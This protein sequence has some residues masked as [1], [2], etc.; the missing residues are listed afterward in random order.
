MAELF[1]LDE[2]GTGEGQEGKAAP[3]ETRSWFE[4]VPEAYREVPYLQQFKDKNFD[5]FVKSSVEAHKRVGG[6]VVKPGPD[7]TPEELERFM[8]HF[9]PKSPDEYELK[10]PEDVQID[11]EVLTKYKERMWKR[12]ATP[13]AAN[14]A[15]TMFTEL[16]TQG[17]EALAKEAELKETAAREALRQEF[18]DK[19]AEKIA[20]A[21]RVASRFGGDDFA[22]AIKEKGLH[23]EPSFI[24]TLATI[25]ASLTE[26]SWIEGA[27]TSFGT[28]ADIQQKIDAIRH[29]PN[30][31][32]NHENHPLHKQRNREVLDL[33]DQ[34]TQREKAERGL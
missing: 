19:M 34:L 2:P 3:Q 23:L 14:E 20:Q 33:Y 13:E 11:P 26:D 27:K 18:G 5:E 8:N 30:D 31:P 12:G 10:L 9:R 28:S 21:N 6:A 17:Q 15:M 4:S 16:Y 22:K 29:D 25:G 1:D 32:F 24:K 7:A